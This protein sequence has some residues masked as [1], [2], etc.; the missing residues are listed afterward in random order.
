MSQ[1]SAQGEFAVVF[2]AVDHLTNWTLG[3][4]SREGELEAKV[5]IRTIGADKLA[6]DLAVVVLAASLAIRRLGDFES[7]VAG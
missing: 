1:H 6:G 2:E 7:I 4:V 3:V 5:A